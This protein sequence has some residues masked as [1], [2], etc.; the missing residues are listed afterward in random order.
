LEN[1]VLGRQGG[2]A[3]LPAKSF[4]M[5]R[6]KKVRKVKISCGGRVLT[7]TAEGNTEKSQRTVEEVG[8]RDGMGGLGVGLC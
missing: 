4:S 8:K 7:N 1:Q 3:Y 5:P 6:N 2:E